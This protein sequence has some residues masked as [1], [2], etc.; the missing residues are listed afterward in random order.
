MNKS[1]PKIS[2]IMSVYN[3][4]AFL[5][6]SI[7]SILNQTFADFK[8]IIID[9]CSTDNSG[10]IITEYAEKDPR[11]VLV[12]NQENIGLTKSLN[13]GLKIAQGKYIARQD[14][15]DVS[16]PERFEKQV[17]YMEAH[18]SVALVSSGV[19]YID[20]TGKKLGNHIP[21]EDPIVLRWQF[22]FKNPLRHSTVLWCRELIDN[23]V[24][25][26][27]PHFICCQDYDLW[28]RIFEC[29]TV[30]TLPLIL[31]QMRRHSKSISLN[32]VKIQDDLSAQITYRQL[33]HYFSDQNL[34]EQDVLNLR[35]IPQQ[36]GILQPQYFANLSHLS[37]KQA[38]HNYL[39]LVRQYSIK[40]C[41]DINTNSLKQ[42]HED[43]ERSIVNLFK[44]CLR[45]RWIMTGCKMIL[46]YLQAFPYRSFAIIYKIIYSVIKILVKN[47]LFFSHMNIKFNLQ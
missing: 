24:G 47:K 6:E 43:N 36:S 13:K 3:G 26:Y 32:K 16:L 23:K 1:R 38:V 11:I 44:H 46:N 17:A 18:P 2:V 20:E 8:F 42:W 41:F 40:H 34:S 25:N 7:E 45:R 5:Q 19:E 30:D 15:D 9:D 22:L 33:K 4:S 14:A 28:T 37:F 35:V 29:F 31:V 10:D 27:D 21:P 12:K 39:Q